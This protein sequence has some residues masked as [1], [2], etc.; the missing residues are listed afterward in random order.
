MQ[1]IHNLAIVQFLATGE[2]PLP[3]LESVANQIRSESPNESWPA[4]PSWNLLCYHI[5]L[6]HFSVGNYS[7]CSSRLSELWENS[8]N[9]DRLIVLCTALLSIELYIRNGDNAFVDRAQAFLQQ[10]FSNTE[11]VTSFLSAKVN[12]DA[13]VASVSNSVQF[14]ALRANVAKASH[15]P[16]EE[17]KPLLESALSSVSISPDIKNRTLLPVKR[18]IP[19]ACAALC[20]D[21]QAR[22]ITI[23][24]TCDEQNHFAI[25]NNRGIYE[26]LQN[27]YS[28]ALLHFS[29]ALDSRHNNAVVYPYHQIIY[30]IGL[31]LLMRQKAR[32]AFKFLHSIIPLMSSSPYLWLR[33][34]ECC[35]L[36]YKQRVS[37]LRQRTQQTPVIARTLCTATRSFYIL[38]QTDF[39]LYSKYPLQGDGYTAD[40]NLE[41]AEKCSRNAIALCNTD[42]LQTVKHSAELVCAFV[43]LELG[44]GKRAADMGKAVSSA[45]NVDAQ[46]QFLAKI[47]SA[48][49][50][51][52]MGD[53]SEARGILSRLM[54]ESNKVR[55]KEALAV[56][57]I[58]FALVYMASQD[59]RKAQDQLKRAQESA[60]SRPEVVL[61]K[62]AFELKNRKPQ[63]AIAALNQ[64]SS[65]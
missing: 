60:A 44:D 53:A 11:A 42:D 12:D 36:F 54:I 2:N 19:I 16:P 20:L 61:T 58:T 13:F 41:F 49:G 15:L 28:S 46:R 8:D 9:A 31:S 27:R 40:L 37:K 22:Y 23:L 29:K 6:Y 38:P 32:K 50:N 34:S 25:L 35:V 26:L 30:N 33:L 21:D 4:H 5:C 1:E 45:Q 62:V 7:E 57:S 47:Y 24:E 64:Y 65:A 59:M 52:M 3:S 48:Q 39:K 10:H 51:S 43:S 55:E 18:V 63:F 14:A 56:H 17:A